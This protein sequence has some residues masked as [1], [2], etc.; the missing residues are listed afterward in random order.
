MRATNKSGSNSSPVIKEGFFLTQSSVVDGPQVTKGN[1]NSHVQ[2]WRR[3]RAQWSKMID[4]GFS[5]FCVK[6][7]KVIFVRISNPNWKCAHIFSLKD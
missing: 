1:I 3:G 7:G 4:F 5:S 6:K 2:T